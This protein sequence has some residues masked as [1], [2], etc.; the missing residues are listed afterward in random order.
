MMLSGLS[1]VFNQCLND[2]PHARRSS[3]TSDTAQTPLFIPYT[4]VRCPLSTIHCSVIVHPLAL[5]EILSSKERSRS[6]V[7]SI[8]YGKRSISDR[9]GMIIIRQGANHPFETAFDDAQ[10]ISARRFSLPKWVWKVQR[11]LGIGNE[12]RLQTAMQVIDSTVL[13]FISESIERRARGE[14]SAGTAKNIVS[15]VLDSSDMKG[16]VDPELLRSIVIA[17][18]VAGRDTSAQ[19]LSWFIYMLSQH[20]EVE[21]RVRN[22]MLKEIPRLTSEPGYFPTMEEVQSLT[23]LEAAIKET[24]RLYPAASFNLKHCEEDTF[25]L[26]STFIPGEAQV[27][28]PY[29]AMGRM[30]S[31]WGSDCEAYKPERFLDPETGK[32]V[33]MSPFKFNAF[34]AG[35]RICLGMNLAMLEMKIVVAG[36]LS[37]FHISVEPDQ[38]VTYVRSISLPMKNPFMVHIE[39]VAAPVA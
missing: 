27:G 7:E 2:T 10:E 36:L 20:P 6:R 14:T 16:E 35:P 34:H 3:F 8:H 25:L 9:D 22:E 5:L 38:E 17:A 30:V 39:R 32:L 28:L 11:L 18:M 19:T 12:G 23:Y 15:L 31:I 21:S 13:S 33:Q 4:A 1:P 29:Y 26:D 37:R 24:L